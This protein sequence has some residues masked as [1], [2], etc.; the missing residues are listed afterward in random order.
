MLYEVGD[1]VKCLFEPLYWDEI[2]NENNPEDYDEDELPE[3]HPGFNSE[4]YEM[5]NDGNAYEI[6]SI[7]EER[8]WVALRVN[9]HIWWWHTEWISMPCTRP[10]QLSEADKASPHIGVITKIIKMQAARERKGYA[11]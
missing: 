6:I 10:K 3:Y 2:E 11:F 9:G 7:N 5:I 8:N 4:M 1:Y